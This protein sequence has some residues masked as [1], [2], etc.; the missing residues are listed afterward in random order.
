MVHLLNLHSSMVRLETDKSTV[1]ELSYKYLHS[2]MV[3][4]E[5]GKTL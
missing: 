1:F 4:L 5:T 2:S 3:R